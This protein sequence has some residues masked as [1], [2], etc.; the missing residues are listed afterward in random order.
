MMKKLICLF[1]S[2]ISISPLTFGQDTEKEDIVRK[3]YRATRIE[4]SPDIDGILSEELWNTGVWENEFIQIRP[5]DG[6]PSKQR[7]EFKVLFDDNNLYVAIKCFDTSPDSIVNRLTRRDETDGDLAGIIIDSFHD[8]RTAF[9][10]GL[11]S[12]GVKSDFLMSNDGFDENH[13][14]DPNWWARTS[15]NDEGWIAEMKIPFSQLRF[16]KNSGDVWGFN[17]ARILYRHDEQSFWQAIP[18]DAPGFVHRMGELYGLDEIRPRKI[19]DI[20]PYGVAQAE[21]FKKEAGNPFREDGRK[22]RINGGIDTKIGIT[23]NMTMDLTINPDFGQVEADPSV[24]NLT[25]YETYF[26][27]KRPFFIEGQNITSFKIGLGDGDSGNDNLFYS[28]RIGRNPHGQPDLE[29]GWYDE[30]PNFTTILGA[31]KLTGKT[32]NGLSLGFIE[33]VTAEE[34]AEID[35]GNDRIFQTVEPLTNYL[36]GRVQKDFKEGNTLIGA[37]VTSTNRDLDQNLGSFMHKSAYTGGVDFTQYFKKKNWMFNVNLAFSQV[38]GTKEAIAETQRSSARYFQRPDNDHIDFDPD[39]TSLIGNAGMI[40]LQKQNGHFN[41]MIGSIWKTPGFEANDLG[42]MQ[43]SDEVV[44]VIW[45]G[46]KAWDPK[47][48]YR[49]YNFGGNV[50]VVN[51]FGGNIT[52]KGFESHGNMVFKNYWNAWVG[53]NISTSHLSPGLLRGGP[54]MKIPGNISFRAG[55]QTDY[56]KKFNFWVNGNISRGFEKY[57]KSSYSEICFN[58]KPTNYLDFTF[59][60][61]YSTSRTDLQY[62]TNS[63]YNGN[64]RYIFGSIDRKTISTSFRV[65]FYLSPDLTLQYWGQPFVASGKYYDHKYITAPRAD[66]YKDRFHIYTAEQKSFDGNN[67]NLDENTDGITDYS[68]SLKNFNVQEFLSNLVLRWEYNPGSSVYLV[69]NQTRN[70]SNNTG[71]MDYFNNIGDLFDRDNNI[72]N[73]VFLI[74]FSYRFGLR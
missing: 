27:E 62:V 20:T 29:D 49:S 73:N 34:K 13:S 44:S 66:N 24:V 69:W 10:F 26:S 30:K 57:Q 23:N 42:Y 4:T 41:L 3:K 45:A 14:W 60:P 18:R 9:V 2:L 8:L 61:S 47:G 22:Y 6:R 63:N 19:F 64:N 28:R 55:F 15:V 67:I 48:I 25:A 70:Y 74:K 71:M 46:Y 17:V 38:N 59:R 35:T 52:G 32:K 72:P 58:Y 65:N 51:N 16:D 31:A 36:I 54:M 33:A 1:L 7:T 11:S 50:Y 53:S 68:F 56:R 40:E 21:T 5:Y 39:R 37:M 12:A 43:E